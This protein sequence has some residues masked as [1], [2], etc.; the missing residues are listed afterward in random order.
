MNAYYV[1]SFLAP[2]LTFILYLYRKLEPDNALIYI[3]SFNICF[4]I[5]ILTFPFTGVIAGLFAYILLYIANIVRKSSLNKNTDK[6]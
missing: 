3:L 2:Y 1:L 5:S 6:N 4:V